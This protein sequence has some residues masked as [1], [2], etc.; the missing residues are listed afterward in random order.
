MLTTRNPTF[1]IPDEQTLNGYLATGR[2]G[3]YISPNELYGEVVVYRKEGEMTTLEWTS[4][5]SHDHLYAVDIAGKHGIRLPGILLVPSETETSLTIFWKQPGGEQ[6]AT[7]LDLKQY[8]LSNTVMDDQQAREIDLLHL[9]ERSEQREPDKTGTI[10][11]SNLPAQETRNAGGVFTS[12]VILSK[13]SL[14]ASERIHVT[15][16][17]TYSVPWDLT[18]DGDYIV[19]QRLSSVDMAP[20]GSIRRPLRLTENST[21]EVKRYETGM[22]VSFLQRVSIPRKALDYHL[23]GSPTREYIDDVTYYIVQPPRVEREHDDDGTEGENENREDADVQEQSRQ[24][25]Y[26]DAKSHLSDL[27]G[28]LKV[29]EDP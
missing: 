1:A 6:L 11:Q 3:I 5:Q 13:P 2:P 28:E 26:Y 25:V 18:I 21:I 10:V 20:E 19:L 27:S 24:D 22:H 23:P 12:N 14:I 17:R 7:S 16:R 29:S 15:A 8:E 4:G 9:S